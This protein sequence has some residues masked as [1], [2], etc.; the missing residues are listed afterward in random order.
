MASLS[1]TH[2]TH[3]THP[4]TTSTPLATSDVHST[5]D[6]KADSI[7]M[8]APA[9]SSH[10]LR[11]IERDH[12]EFR[13]LFAAFSSAMSLKDKDDIKNELIRGLSIHDYI[14][15]TVLFPAFEKEV[16]NGKDRLNTYKLR[17]AELRKLM[18]T[19][20][21]MKIDDLAFQPT[22]TSM[23]KEIEE[24]M[25][26]KER[27]FLPALQVVITP[28]RAEELG[29]DM[30]K[31]RKTAPTRPHTTAATSTVLGALAAP[32]DKL[33]DKARDFAGSS[34]DHPDVVGK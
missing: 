16:P 8:T 26:Y 30:D 28:V 25:I 19:V 31:A 7:F 34:K 27:E 10:F 2:P 20:D 33:K 13:R 23:T 29:H 11:T 6:K 32:I 1:T 4:I 22:F 5:S 18:T 24:G 21:K 3:P 14:T 17:C 9:G 12:T 15:E